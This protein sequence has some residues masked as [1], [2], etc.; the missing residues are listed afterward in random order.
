MAAAYQRISGGRLMLNIVTGGEPR[1]QARF[2]DHR[3]QGRAVRP[4]RGVP[5]VVRG[6]W[7]RGA[8]RLRRASTRRRGRAWS[9]AASTRCPTSTS[10]ARRRPAGPV[11]AQARR[12]LPDLGRA[13]RAGARRRSPGC[14][15]WPPSEGRTLRFGLRIHTLSRDT[16]RRRGRTPSGCSTVSTRRPSRRRRRPSARASPPASADAGAAR[17]PDV[18]PDAH[19]LE[20]SPEPVGGRRAGPRRRRHG[21]GRQPRGGGRPDR[22]VPR[23]RHR[24]VHPVGLPARRGGVLVRARA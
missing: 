19:E 11:A 8:V 14:G 18:V 1:E 7:E 24:R 22:G 3:A 2:G 23:A 13:A 6:T 9:A 21:A 5:P 4:D 16:R 15:G 17:R 10:A 12:R 20:V